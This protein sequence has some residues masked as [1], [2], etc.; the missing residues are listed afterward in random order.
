[1]KRIMMIA[2]MLL[3]AGAGNAQDGKIVE[4]YLE[5][6]ASLEA[7]IKVLEKGY[8]VVKK[9]TD[10]IS[11]IKKG[12]LSL[13]SDYFSSLKS[14]N[15]SIKNYVRVGDIIALQLSILS[16]YNSCRK[17][18]STGS[19]FTSGEVDFTYGFLAKML[20][21][22]EADLDVLLTLT[23]SGTTSMSDDER[24]RR[25]DELYVDMQKIYSTAQSFRQNVLLIGLYRQQQQGD[26]QNGKNLYGLP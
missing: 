21:A 20:N 4:Y 10:I 7:Y 24:L 16:V 22:S 17:Q 1:M 19:W 3:L 5:Q 15:P 25:V 23:T 6:I 11:N 18:V 14:V 8:E 2:C 13:H 12:D 26:I 9:G